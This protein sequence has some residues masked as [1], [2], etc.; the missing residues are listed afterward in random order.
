LKFHL[1]QGKA[2]AFILD[3]NVSEDRMGGIRFAFQLQP[4]TFPTALCAPFAATQDF[5]LV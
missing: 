4:K 5:R 1:G 2:S 3:Q